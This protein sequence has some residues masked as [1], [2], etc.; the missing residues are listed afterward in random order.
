MGPQAK[1]SLGDCQRDFE[2]HAE[3]S[4]PAIHLGMAEKKL[5]RTEIAGLAIDMGKLCPA[6]RMCAAGRRVETDG[7]HPFPDQPGILARRDVEPLMEAA[8][9]EVF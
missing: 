1:S 9:P 7:F 3:I 5:N 6:H 8:G 2:F 4:H